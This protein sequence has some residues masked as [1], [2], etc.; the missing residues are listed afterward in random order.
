MRAIKVIKNIIKF[1]LIKIYNFENLEKTK[2]KSFII[3][4]DILFHPKLLFLRLTRNTV[5]FNSIVPNS[6]F[7]KIDKNKIKEIK[8]DSNNFLRDDL[9]KVGSE[10]LKK[11]G[12]VIIENAFDPKTVDDFVV[13]SNKYIQN[14]KLKSKE[15]NK[16][17]NQNLDKIPL[18]KDKFILSD[19][20]SKTIDLSCKNDLNKKNEF[21]YARQ[22][23]IV[24]KFTPSGEN[25]KSNW[26]SGWHVDFPTQFT[27]TVL[28]EDL[29]PNC[30]RMQALPC[31][32][33]LPLIPGKHYDI[34][35]S[36][37]KKDFE[38]KI[39]DIYGPKGTLYIH[40]GN[41]LHRNFP[42]NGCNRY[43]WGTVYTID[44]LFVIGDKSH[45][46]QFFKES[47]SLLKSLNPTELKRIDG[48]LNAEYSAKAKQLTYI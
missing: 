6:I 48:L 19:I 9:I 35:P 27:A 28:L 10:I 38:N 34:S 47:E 5:K 25:T 31:T 3:L 18:I 40:D 11:Y 43:L 1:F 14:D 20:I 30:T 29:G 17:L 45:R 13:V 24:T 15:T 36:V 32:K 41:T 23:P 42:V 16:Y 44:K 8:I 2:L 7:K 37:K 12:L 22:Y 33:F 46:D 39:I 4:R 26:T 21:A